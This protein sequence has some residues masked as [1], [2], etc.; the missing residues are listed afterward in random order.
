MRHL[1]E[2][3]GGEGEDALSDLLGVSE[4]ADEEGHEGT[5]IVVVADTACLGEGTDS[6]LTVGGEGVV[7]EIGEEGDEA[8]EGDTELLGGDVSHLDD[9]VEDS[10]LGLGLVGVGKTGHDDIE[11][12]SSGLRVEE[13]LRKQNVNNWN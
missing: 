9:V 2:G 7:E 5:E 11:D 13:S 4:S 10:E 8:S 1:D 12:G 6:S 3:E